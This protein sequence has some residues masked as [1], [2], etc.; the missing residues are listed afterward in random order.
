[1]VKNVP[2]NAGNA[3]DVSS[4]PSQEDPLESEMASHSSIL[5]WR[6]PWT[7]ESGR[8]QSVGLQRGRRD[9][10]TFTYLLPLW[11][12]VLSNIKIYMGKQEKQVL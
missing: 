3:K 8:L 12:Y 9:Q 2:A 6:T 10:V 4:I 7:E 1:M 11:M 5:A